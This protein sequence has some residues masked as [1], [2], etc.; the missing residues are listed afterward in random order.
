MR[1]T[2][3]L[4]HKDI[5]VYYFATQAEFEKW[6]AK[7][8]TREGAFWIRFY[9]KSSPTPTIQIGDAVDVALCYGWID[10]LINGFDDQSYLIRFTHRRPKS[11]WSKVNV[12]KVEKLIAAGRMQPSGQVHIDSAKADGRWAAAY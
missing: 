2:D 5:P 3:E 12:A 11:V 4:M 9:K 7:N 8:H 1:T 10:G 6:L